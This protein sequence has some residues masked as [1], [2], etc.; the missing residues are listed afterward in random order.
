MAACVACRITV[1]APVSVT[2]LPLIVAG[3][4]STLYVTAP[5][6]AEL[7]ETVNAASPYVFAEIAAKLSIGVAGVTVSVAFWLLADPMRFLTTTIK[8]CVPVGVVAGDV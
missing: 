6:D 3:P 7:A 5:L 8:L 2:V 1:P 4:L